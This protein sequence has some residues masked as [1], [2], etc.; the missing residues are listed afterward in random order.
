M[1]TN[2]IMS[3]RDKKLWAYAVT[4]ALA[5]CVKPFTEEPDHEQQGF[6]FRWLMD[7]GFNLDPV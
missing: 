4:A 7:L 5:D 2:L 6:Y 1:N 3:D